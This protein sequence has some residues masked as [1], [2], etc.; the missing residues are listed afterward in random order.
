MPHP[1]RA[2]PPPR[3]S[4]LWSDTFVPPCHLGRAPSPSHR[5]G[6][7]TPHATWSPASHPSAPARAC[8]KPLRH[9]F[10]CRGA[11]EPMPEDP[12]AWVCRP[13]APRVHAEGPSGMAGDHQPCNSRSDRCHPLS[14]DAA[15]RP[16]SRGPCM[17]EPAPAWVFRPRGASGPCRSPL[18]HGFSC[19]GAPKPMPEAPPAWV[20]R[21]RAPRVHAG[22]PSGMAG[23]YQPRNMRGDRWARCRRHAAWPGVINRAIGE[24]TDVA[25]PPVTSHSVTHPLSHRAMQKGGAPP[26]PAGPRPGAHVYAAGAT[27]P[28]TAARRRSTP[29][30]S[31]PRSR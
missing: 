16:L 14:R 24:V 19:R 9:G 2:A 1:C 29:A 7:G 11:S 13:L 20:F 6:A 22:G 26:S 21:P 12:P 5:G 31:R 30:S 10:S 15:T 18:R 28:G 27:A 23:G 25:V 3:Q 8:R 17:P 4:S